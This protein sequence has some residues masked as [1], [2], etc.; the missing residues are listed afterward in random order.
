M[1]DGDLEAIPAEL[2]AEVQAKLLELY[3]IVASVVP[4]A[5]K[6]R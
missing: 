5:A 6:Q 4:A 3:N 2:R 1:T